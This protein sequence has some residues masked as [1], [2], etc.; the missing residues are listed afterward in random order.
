MG[1]KSAVKTP[2]DLVITNRIPTNQKVVWSE[3]E[4]YRHV[5]NRPVV[6]LGCVVVPRFGAE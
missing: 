3:G 6:Y 1:C 2:V 4:Q 5:I